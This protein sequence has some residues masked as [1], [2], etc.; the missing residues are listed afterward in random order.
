[1]IDAGHAAGADDV[2]DRQPEHGQRVGERVEVDVVGE[3]D[4]VAEP[5]EEQLHRELLRE[6]D[7][8]GEHL[9]EV[10]DAVAL[11]GHA[12][13]AEAE[14]EA[15]PLLGIDAAVAQDVR[16]DHAAAAELEPV[17]ARA[18]GCRTRRTAR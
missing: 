6:A 1:M 10:A 11:L 12:V 16:V 3:G 8:A 15:A 9:A 17:A 14:G 4:V 13:D 2:L 18:C 5:G 7:V